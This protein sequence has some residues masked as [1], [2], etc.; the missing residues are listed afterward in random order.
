MGTWQDMESMLGLLS[1]KP[2]CQHIVFLIFVNQTG[3][4]LLFFSYN[5]KRLEVQQVLS[6]KLQQSSNLHDLLMWHQTYS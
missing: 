3:F 5:I 4:A 6:V 1:V 2:S